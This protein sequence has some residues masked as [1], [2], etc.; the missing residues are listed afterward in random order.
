MVGPVT[1]GA[2]TAYAAYDESGLTLSSL[3]LLGPCDGDNVSP[4]GD[5]WLTG[6]T[7]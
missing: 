4:E 3:A 7:A 1:I 5:S 6:H 2:A